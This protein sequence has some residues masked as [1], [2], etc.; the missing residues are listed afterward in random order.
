LHQGHF[1]IRA[2]K[3]AAVFAA[4]LLL[5][6][7]NK[8]KTGKKLKSKQ[9]EKGESYEKSNKSKK[10]LANRYRCRSSGL[11]RAFVRSAQSEARSPD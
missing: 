3:V 10:V 7:S 9:G 11:S 6:T 1:E 5:C 4:P 2:F 8:L